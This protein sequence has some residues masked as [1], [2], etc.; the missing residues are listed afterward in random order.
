[1]SYSRSRKPENLLRVVFTAA[2]AD[3][4]VKVGG[5]GDVAGTLPLYLSRIESIEGKKVKFDIRLI[6]PYHKA[7]ADQYR[8]QKPIATFHIPTLKSNIQA[9]VYS[10]KLNDVIVYLVDGKPITKTESVYSRDSKLDGEKFTFFSLACLKLID[11][12]ELAP[13]ILHAN[14]WHTA[15]V[16]YAQSREISAQPKKSVPSKVITLHN[17]P[18]M[19]AGAE[20]SLK[21]YSIPLSENPDLPDWARGIPLPMGLASADAIVAVSST[22]AKEI[23]TEAFGCGLEKFLQKNAERITGI[24]NGLDYETWNPVNDEYIQKKFSIN[25]IPDRRENKKALQLEFHL[26]C[27][28]KAPLLILISR[29]DIQKGIDLA[30]EAIKL[31]EHKKWQAIFLGSGDPILERKVLELQDAFP[32]NFRAAIRFDTSLSHRMYAGGDILLMPSRYEPC[33]LAQMIAMRYGCIPIAR[34]TGGLVDTIQYSPKSR[35]TGYLFSGT[36]PGSMVKILD[37]ALRDFN[38]KKRWK[39]IQKRAM[40]VDFSWTGSA[41]KYALLYRDL[42]RKQRGKSIGL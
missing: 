25:S 3:P 21:K 32:S 36:T 18:F 26:P 31:L 41:M 39:S 14:D 24:I 10:T 40:S 19:G 2:E 13:D 9:V 8:A 22:Y 7:I 16:L 42:I 1:M 17:L 30:I 37:E 11:E 5:L 29:L 27:D 34:A 12:L 6:I 38:E 33:G 28:E 15:L 35:Q 4:F 20:K 23:Q